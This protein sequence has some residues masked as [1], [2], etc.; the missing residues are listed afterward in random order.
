MKRAYASRTECM[1][2]MVPRTAIISLKLLQSIWKVFTARYELNIYYKSGYFLSVMVK[3]LAM[4]M[5][6]EETDSSKHS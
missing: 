1:M 3:H 6:G 2:Y 4:K 5:Y